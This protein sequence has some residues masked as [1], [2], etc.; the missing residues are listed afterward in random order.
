MRTHEGHDGDPDRP[1]QEERAAEEALERTL[2]RLGPLLGQRTQASGPRSVFVAA[3]RHRLLAA[4]N[5]AAVTAGALLPPSAGGQRPP[6]QGQGHTAAGTPRRAL[7]L[8]L[9]VVLGG[10]AIILARTG[11]TQEDAGRHGG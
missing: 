5:G 10:A 4:W 8:V 7:A 2:R 6:D 1:S 11:Q 9:L 3:L